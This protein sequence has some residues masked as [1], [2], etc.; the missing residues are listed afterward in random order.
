MAVPEA[1]LRRALSYHT[2]LIAEDDWE[3]AAAVGVGAVQFTVRKH[4]NNAVV[5]QVLPGIAAE[6]VGKV[7][8][9]GGANVGVSAK[10]ISV[11]TAAG[12]V[13]T[14]TLADTDALPGALAVGDTLTLFRI[15]NISEVGGA[16]LPDGLSGHPDL[17]STLDGSTIQQPTDLQSSLQTALD[18]TTAILGADAV[19]TTTAA[20]DCSKMR[21]IVGTVISDQAGTLLVEQAP[22][23]I[24]WDVASSFAV[25]AGAAEG[26]G[27]GFSVEVVAPSMRL[28]YTN[29]ATP[30]TVFRLYAW[31]TPNQ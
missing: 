25:T 7:E 30:Q 29:G 23:G 10:V 19:Y 22:D 26:D 18:S 13:T 2:R 27:Q 3:V 15:D 4:S 5:P 8:F 11:S 12:P 24:N 17:P 28:K 20:V 6:Y 9:T 1:N 31:G 14:V 21:R 16:A